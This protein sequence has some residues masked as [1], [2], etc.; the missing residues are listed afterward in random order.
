[1][2]LCPGEVALR[3]NFIVFFEPPADIFTDGPFLYAECFPSR[4]EKPT[5]LE[6]YYCEENIS[7][8]VYCKLVQCCTLHLSALHLYT[9]FFCWCLA[10]AACVVSIRKPS[11]LI[12]GFYHLTFFLGWACQHHN[13]CRSSQLPWFCEFWYL[14][15][16]LSLPIK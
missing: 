13:F 11:A 5:V 15:I 1:M 2:I 7:W 8:G 9:Y 14:W 3:V 10:S 6:L 12:S 4:K 16:E